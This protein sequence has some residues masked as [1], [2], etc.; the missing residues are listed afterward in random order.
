MKEQF[1]DLVILA[2]SRRSA[3]RAAAQKRLELFSQEPNEK[4][5]PITVTFLI[6]ID[7]L[8]KAQK[9][10]HEFCE[11]LRVSGAELISYTIQDPPSY[12]GK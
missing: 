9:K 11:S 1:I 6:G 2:H 3:E 8:P 10:I 5:L 7:C 4:T 12:G